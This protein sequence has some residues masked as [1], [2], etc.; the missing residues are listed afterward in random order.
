MADV[1]PETGEITGDGPVEPVG[2][3]AKVQR[4]LTSGWVPEVATS[5]EISGAIARRLLD[6]TDVDDILNPKQPLGIKEDGYLDKPFTL[7]NVD[8]APSSLGERNGY[9]AVFDA[10]MLE[11]GEEVILTC[12]GTNV[13]ATALNLL[14]RDLLPRDVKVIESKEMTSNGYF[15]WW[16]VAPGYEWA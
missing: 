10:V 13:V 12:G 11:D 15:P 1:D 5:A 7:R 9:Y 14:Q 2:I 3:V 4:A 16:M 6:Q 8:F